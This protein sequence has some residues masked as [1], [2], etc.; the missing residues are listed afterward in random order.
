MAGLRV[1][2]AFAAA[3]Q[4]K[5]MPRASATTPNGGYQLQSDQLPSLQIRMWRG[6]IRKWSHHTATMTPSPTPLPP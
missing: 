4:V 3:L 5:N 1:S 6:I 2:R